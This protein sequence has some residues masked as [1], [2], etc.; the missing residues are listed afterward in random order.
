MNKLLKTLKTNYKN[1]Q[2]MKAAIPIASAMVTARSMQQNEDEPE[3]DFAEIAADS[4]RMVK[5]LRKKIY[6]TDL[7]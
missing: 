4:V 6:G 5:S 2:L 7:L 3:V 1:K